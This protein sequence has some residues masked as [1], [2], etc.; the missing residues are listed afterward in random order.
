MPLILA[1]TSPQRRDLLALLGLPFS[2]MAS[3][4]Q[5][6][7]NS[8]NL[9]RQVAENL[10][11]QKAQAVAEHHPDSIILGGDT[12]IE[13]DH[14]ILGKPATEKEARAMLACLSGR[15]HQVHSGIAL[16]SPSPPSVLHNADSV[17]VWIKTLTDLNIEAYLSTK[18]WEGRAGSY[19]IQGVGG[20]LIERIEGDFT[21]VVGL[22]LRKTAK[23]LEK[24][25]V[26]LSKSVE[27]I[28]RSKPYTNWTAF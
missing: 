15:A 7:F 4:F 5:E 18:E 23:L 27:E 10:A 25:G 11:V 14:Q 20:Q 21:T 17:T 1:S 26:V 8:S 28:Y 2:I 9:P 3:E 22:P 6:D 19:S 24:A 16:V 12:L 13:V